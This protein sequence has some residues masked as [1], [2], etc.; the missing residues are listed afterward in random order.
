MTKQFSKKI[1]TV[2]ALIF[3]AVFQS[4]ALSFTDINT[5]LADI[6]FWASDNNEGSTSFRSLLI[7]FGG[8][9]ESM[10]S[11]YTGLSDDI[12]YLQFNPSG[13]ALQK[14]TQFSIFHNSWIADSKLDSVAYTTRI[15]N[16]GLGGY[17]SC[18]Y[19][20]FS[21]YNIFGDRV[22]SN[23]YSESVIALNISKNFFAGYDFKGISI[24]GS[25]KG[26][27]RSMPDYTDND[28]NDVI[29]FS[30]V[31]QSSLALMVDVGAM[32]QFNFLKYFAS[33]EPNVRI[34]VAL[35]NIGIGFTGFFGNTGVQLDD[36]LP[37]FLSAGISLKP[38]K[39]VTI[40]AD[41]KQPF[42]LTNLGSY[43]IPYIGAGVSVQFTSFLSILGGFELKGGNPK[44]SA[45]IEFELAKIRLNFNYSLDLTT[46][47][48]PVNK[49]SLSA[50]LLLGDRGRS[51][52]DARVD[53]HYKA[54]LVYYMEGQWELAIKEWE[55]CLN[56]NKGFDP[57]RLAIQSAEAIIYTL[58]KAK[59]Y[60][61]FE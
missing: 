35:Q 16:L 11:A 1:I 26:A 22:S 34:G 41:I 39:P 38:I 31:S 45:G 50:K 42:N 27:W 61:T 52:I 15:G 47:Y 59:E 28:T 43:L 40:S 58:N 23:Y 55:K 6:F 19:V 36:G 24:G 37:S 25:V 49:I 10:G 7:P 8:R 17:F 14:E 60:Q 30:G 32:M 4:E 33:R 57:A 12:S 46:S 9:S 51:L 13:S 21:E 29:S 5:T 18:F 2:F 3:L 48:S 44:I 20:P 53:E 56:L 54:G